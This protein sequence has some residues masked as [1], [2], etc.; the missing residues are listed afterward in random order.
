MM[1]REV[2]YGAIFSN[3]LRNRHVSIT[4]LCHQYSSMASSMLN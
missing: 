1:M 2:P 3:L 4:P